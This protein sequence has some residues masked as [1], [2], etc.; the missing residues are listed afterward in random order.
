MRNSNG[1]KNGRNEVKK[2]AVVLTRGPAGEDSIVK[3]VLAVVRSRPD[4]AFIGRDNDW[5]RQRI[6]SAR[7]Y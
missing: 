3:Q 1:T 5:E 4:W 6:A 7:G 2:D